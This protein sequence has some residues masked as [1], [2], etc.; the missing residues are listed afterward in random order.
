MPVPADLRRALRSLARRRGFAA[1]VVL[2]LS[3]ACSLPAVVLSALDRHFWRP[4]DLVDSERLFTLQIL[5]EDGGFSP[6]S[7]PEYAQ[8]RD[9]GAE[10]FSLATF[11]RFDFTLVAGGVPTRVNVALASGNFFTVLG[12]RPAHGR[13]LSPPDDRPDSAPTSLVISHRAWTTRFGQDPGLVGRPVRLGGQPFT[14]V[15]VAVNPLPGPAH[16]PDF[17]APL[18]A[19]SRLFPGSAG[20]LLGPTA[21]WLHT[22]GRLHPST[23]R[24]DAAVLAALARDR[25]PAEVAGARTDNWRFVARPVNHVRLG[26]G[27]H[28]EATRFLSILLLISTFFL[29]AACCN[30]ALLL[31]ARGAERSHDLAVRHAL[32]ASALDLARPFAIELLVLVGAGGLVAI[33]MLRWT[34]PFVSALPQLAPLGATDVLDASVALWTLAVAGSV[35]VLVCGGVLLAFAL[36]PPALA[37]AP[38]TTTGPGGRQRALVTAQVAVSCVL[39]VTAGLLARSAHGVASVP[40]GFAPEDVL[41]ARI[42]STGDSP[43]DGHA[44]YRRL[45]ATLRSSALVKSAALAWHAPLS[46]TALTVSVEI[47]G[48]AMEVSGNAVSSDYFHTLAVPVLEGREFSDADAADAPRVAVVNRTLADR[49]W[50]GRSAVGRILAFPRSGGD[51]TVVG[52]VD[53]MRYGALTEPALPVAYLPLAQRFFSPAFI[54]L[55]SPTDT[56]MVLQQLRRVVAELD[57]GAPLSD[58]RS[59]SDRVDQALDRWREPAL[60]AGL[61]ALATLVLTMGGLYGVVGLSVRQR[62]RE[63]AVRMALGAHETAVRRMVLAQGLRLVTAGAVIGLVAAFPVTSL[64]GSQLYGIAPYDV[65]TLAAG[66]IALFAAAGL[67]CDLPARRAARL[68]TAAALRTE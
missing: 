53:D 32:G 10:A 51:R 66:L 43:G 64:L 26:P 7:H 31:L 4:L 62:T 28:Q 1:T 61:L 34:G 11:G 46:V 37:G 65:A 41:V 40:R 33:L 29:L 9:T 17:W 12:A 38:T 63:L 5:I 13:L 18:S 15:G 35:W 48:T 59:L 50:P 52:V 16:E 30:V 55:R 2:T 67:A 47:P 39:V 3:L 19:L 6:L 56:G 23:S 36:R 45:L 21:P 22:V 14:V 20:S 8:L 27:Y 68:D 44:F 54:H 57:P 49:L 42:H 60:L 58:V 24:D 25:L